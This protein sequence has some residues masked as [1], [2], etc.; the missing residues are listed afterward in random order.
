[1]TLPQDSRRNS[2]INRA[3]ESDTDDSRPEVAAGAAGKADQTTAS[4]TLG[5]VMLVKENRIKSQKN[6]AGRA[7]ILVAVDFAFTYTMEMIGGPAKV[8]LIC[9]VG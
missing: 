1:M 5:N 8:V 2:K 6:G 4:L 3:A 9:K 7:K